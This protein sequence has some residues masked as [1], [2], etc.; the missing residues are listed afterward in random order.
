M[1]RSFL[2]M[3]AILASCTAAGAAPASSA[4]PA[5]F[6]CDARAPNVCYFR[7]FYA[8]GDRIVVLPAGMKQKVPGVV[9]GRDQ[10]CVALGKAPPVKCARKI[11]GAAYNS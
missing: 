9:I 8:R 1:K 6:G 5:P 7:I 3:A 10:Y 4:P 11:I 2:V